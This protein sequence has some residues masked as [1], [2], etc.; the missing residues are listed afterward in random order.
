MNTADELNALKLKDYKKITLDNIGLDNREMLIEIFGTPDRC[1]H[2][3]DLV[4]KHFDRVSPDQYGIK[5]ETIYTKQNGKYVAMGKTTRGKLFNLKE[6]INSN[7]TMPSTKENV[8]SFIGLPIDMF[9][10]ADSKA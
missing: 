2:I 3:L 10:W 4:N 1:K 8:R 7:G 6:L 9:L 5:I